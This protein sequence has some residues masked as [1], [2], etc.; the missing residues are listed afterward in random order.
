MNKFKTIVLALLVPIMLMGGSVAASASTNTT[1]TWS[2]TAPM[3]Q[4]Q[5]GPFNARNNMWAC[6]ITC[7]GT[8]TA[9]ANGTEGFDG[10]LTNFGVT[11]NFPKGLTAVLTYPD[12]DQTQSDSNGDDKAI[13]SLHLIQSTYAETMPKS[14]DFEAAYDIWENNYATEVMIWVDD[15]NQVPAGSK[16]VKSVNIGGTVYSI[17]LDGKMGSAD[18][19]ISVTRH[20]NAQSGKVRVLSVLNYLQ[21]N[22][23]TESVANGGGKL[24]DI[25]FGW[26]ICSTNGTPET[27]NA[28]SY[29]LNIK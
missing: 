24:A 19:L 27:F 11:A 25:E 15:H 8:E 9:F 1:P 28:S 17:W 12:L 26:E 21:Q 2:S 18:A 4:Q 13:S 6:Q 7:P 29:S 14:G 5:F 3:D 10:S 23:Y 22:G 20:G 16:V